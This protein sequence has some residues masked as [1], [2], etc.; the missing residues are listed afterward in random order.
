[1]G[2]KEKLSK[3]Y[4]DSY[5]KKYGDRMAQ[6]QGSIISVKVEEKTILWIFHKLTATLIVRP[7]RSKSIVKCSYKK[8]K[9]FKKPE[10]LA[11]SQGH[12]VVVQ[13][14]KTKKDK[15]GK[16]TGE[17]IELMNILNLTTKKDLIP[18]DHSQIKKVK[19][20]QQRSK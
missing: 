9:W 14:L 7:E 1:M 2:F 5:M 10:F 18:V 11:L 17:I 20:Q 12:N 8:N 19:Q 4:T 13:G 6:F 3:Y 16:S 15:K